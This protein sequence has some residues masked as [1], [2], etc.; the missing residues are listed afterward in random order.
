[1]GFET[2]EDAMG[3]IAELTPRL[4]RRHATSGSAG[5][6]LQW[7]VAPDGTDSPILYEDEFELPG[8]RAQLRRAALQAAGRAPPARS[9]R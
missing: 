2:P 6:G 9:S 3:E 8:G 7:P 5:A 4:R 1:M